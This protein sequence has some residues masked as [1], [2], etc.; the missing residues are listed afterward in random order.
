MKKKFNYQLAFYG[1][2]GMFLTIILVVACQKDTLTDLELI[3]EKDPTFTEAQYKRYATSYDFNDLLGL[4]GQYGTSTPSITPSFNN[5]YQDIGGGLNPVDNL[6]IP[7]D[8]T[9]TFS[10]YVNNSLIGEGDIILLDIY[11][12]INCDEYF[13]VTLQVETAFGAVF[14]RDMLCFYRFTSGLELPACECPEGVDCSSPFNIFSQETFYPDVPDY[15]YQTQYA[16]WD[17]NQDNFIDTQDILILLGGY[18]G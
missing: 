14:E 15:F 6:T 2:L 7:E 3:Q 8:T 11:N 17:L 16:T 5:Y 12:S 18:G 13:Y 4:L 10:W 1:M 9:Y